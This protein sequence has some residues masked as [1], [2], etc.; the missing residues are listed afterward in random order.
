MASEYLKWK[1]RDV[2]PDEPPPPLTGWPRVKNW[3]YYHAIYL[4]AGAVILGILL[5]M[6]WNVLGIGK[7]KPDYIFAYV[8]RAALPQETREALRTGLASLGEDVNGDGEVSV[9]LRSYVSGGGGDP[10]TAALYAAA[11]Q[12]TLIA[13]ITSGET[14]FFLVENPEVFEAQYQ[15]LAGPDGALPDDDDFSW[16]GRALRWSDCPALAALELGQF[17]EDDGTGG[18]W[19]GSSDE[20]VSG[21]YIG[22][23]GWV[24]PKQNKH[25]ETDLRLWEA[26]TKG[27]VS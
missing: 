17:R 11:A 20:L 10:D 13:D 7:V 22:R 8:G 14:V 6:L 16:E 12:T 19:S 9:E 1:Y 25:A 2:K 21:L 15:I 3:L 23:R 24:D 5:S 4:I 18:V 26:M 27:A